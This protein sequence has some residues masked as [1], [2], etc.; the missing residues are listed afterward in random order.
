MTGKANFIK[1]AE[2]TDELQALE[3]KFDMSQD[4]LSQVFKMVV[5]K[6]QQTQFISQNLF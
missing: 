4:F 5:E 3:E 6:E 1:L 2:Y